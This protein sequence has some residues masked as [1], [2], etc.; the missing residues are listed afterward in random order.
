[1]NCCA[2]AIG[3]HSHGIATSV[4]CSFHA[5]MTQGEMPASLAAVIIGR[6]VFLTAAVFWA[7]ARQLRWKWGGWH[8]F[9]RIDSPG[10]PAHVSP[11][12][13]K[14]DSDNTPAAENSGAGQ[15]AE[16]DSVPPAPIV[17]PL[18]ISKVNT[19]FQLALITACLS[20]A[21]C[22]SPGPPST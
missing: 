15:T 3:G 10:V 9:F 2:K 18:Y 19:V 14:Q 11:S 5:S 12:P 20:Q 22:G 16:T 6:D 21:W 7:R 17:E 4:A 13:Q 8:E 1:M